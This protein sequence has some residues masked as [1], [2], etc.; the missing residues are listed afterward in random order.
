MLIYTSPEH[1]KQVEWQALHSRLP[2]V[3]IKKPSELH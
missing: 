3:T 2:G 1:L